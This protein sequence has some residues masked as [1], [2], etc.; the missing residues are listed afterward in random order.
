MDEKIT[1]E[2]TW[3]D[4]GERVQATGWKLWVRTLPHSRKTHGGKLWLPPKLQ[5]FHGE[6]PHLVTVRGL[7]LSVGP[8]GTAQSFSEGDIV[9]FQRLHFGYMWKLPNAN[10]D[11]Y[12]GD[13]QY[14]GFLD[15]NQ[16]LWT[17]E[18]EED[19]SPPTARA[20]RK[21]RKSAQVEAT[22]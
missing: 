21:S 16:V 11:Q 1:V 3:A 14:I 19:A 8:H 22:K 10:Q 15:A 17:L 2:S 18:P 20:P 6:L 7:V 5:S 12:G 9:E 4:L 13:E